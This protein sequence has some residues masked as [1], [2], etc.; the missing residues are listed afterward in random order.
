VLCCAFRNATLD[1]L[2]KKFVTLC[3]RIVAFDSEE[4]TAMDARKSEKIFEALESFRIELTSW[5]FANTWH[6]LWQIRTASG[7]HYNRGEVQRRW[8]GTSARRSLPHRSVACSLAFRQSGYLE[9]ITR[10]RATRNSRN[11]SSYA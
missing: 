10:E 3:G 2:E 9:R 8:P 1:G 7:G 4:R 11:V 6:A 5:G